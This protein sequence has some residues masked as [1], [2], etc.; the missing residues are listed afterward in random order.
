MW[1]DGG[2]TQTLGVLYQ[3]EGELASPPVP[4]LL[5]TPWV[6]LGTT[7]FIVVS[8]LPGKA[9]ISH[10]SLL[11]HDWLM[12]GLQTETRMLS[13]IKSLAYRVSIHM[14]IS[15]DRLH[16]L[17]QHLILVFFKDQSQ[18]FEILATMATMVRKRL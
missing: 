14:Q 8:P 18:Y 4:K 17:T 9:P 13:I 7:S 15:V 12:A 6:N 11:K 1:R 5:L 16:N 10:Q 3:P 2:A